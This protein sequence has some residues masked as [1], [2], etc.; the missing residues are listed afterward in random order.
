MDGRGCVSDHTS[1]IVISQR[2]CAGALR[3]PERTKAPSDEQCHSLSLS[4]R[5]SAHTGVAPKRV[6]RGSALG[7]Q[8]PFFEDSRNDAR[9]DEQWQILLTEWHCSDRE[10][11]TSSTT[12]P[13]RL[14]AVTPPLTQGR[15]VAQRIK[16]S[17]CRWQPFRYYR[18][19]LWCFFEGLRPRCEACTIKIPFQWKGIFHQTNK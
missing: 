16:I 19:S 9:T 7:V 15:C 4:L 11:V 2:L 1:F 13:S 17:G 5:T 8:S 6:A 3:Q 18:L 12:P 14:N 10:I